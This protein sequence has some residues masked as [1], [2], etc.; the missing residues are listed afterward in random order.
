MHPMQTKPKTNFGL[1]YV[2][3]EVHNTAFQ[4][5]D[6]HPAQG[7]V[8]I[9]ADLQQ[10]R[11]V[12]EKHWMHLLFVDLDDIRNAFPQILQLKNGSKGLRLVG[13]TASGSVPHIVKAMQSGFDEVITAKELPK[14]LP[15]IVSQ[16]VKTVGAAADVVEFHQSRKKAYDFSQILGR[17]PQMHNIF[18]LL[19]KII[20]RKWMTV[21]I[22][23]ETGTGKE[24]IARAIHYN[25]FDE[26]RPFVEVNCGALPETLLESELFGYEKG[27]FTDAKTQK[28]GLF[29]LAENGTLFLDE[30]GDITASTQVKLLK[31]LEEKKIR[32]LGGLRDIQINT[33]I[34]AATNRDLP[35]AIRDGSFRTDLYYR[36]NV[37][38]I[39]LPPLRERGEDVLELAEHFLQQYARDY[40]S[41]LQRFSEPARSLL[42]RYSWPGNV[43][44][45]SH[46]IERIVL[47]GEGEEVTEQEVENAIE[48]DTPLLLSERRQ[49]TGVHIEIPAGGISLD[50]GEKFLIA[51]VLEKM[52][53]NKRRTCKALKVSRPRLDRKIKKYGLSPK[54]TQSQPPENQDS[55]EDA[56]A[57]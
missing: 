54:V 33:R 49:S 27:A 8:F 17:S 24:L 46:V 50:D 43:R 21:L 41:P 44:E 23:G 52:N 47:L 56:P 34:I 15:E 28:K 12:A 36:L 7:E 39:H 51:A 10:A 37:L 2:G 42:L 11:V 40:E 9:V 53:W 30:I 57:E 35:A 29:E 26:F 32:H 16:T 45:L 38:T 14:R 22:R 25:C 3:N 1:L 31:A 4:K 20:K 18:D 13:I 19:S 48:S 6:W 5:V 55:G